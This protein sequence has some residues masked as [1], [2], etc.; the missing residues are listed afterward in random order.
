MFDKVLFKLNMRNVFYSTLSL[1]WA[2]NVLK[3]EHF[4]KVTSK[5]CSLSR[6]GLMTISDISLL[7]FD[8]CH[9]AVKS[10]PYSMIMNCYLDIMKEN[11]SRTTHSAKRL[12]QVCVWLTSSHWLVS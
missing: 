3:Y 10:D 2:V 6:D 12:P 4:T 11:A 1:P 5:L 8:E 9:H 7:I